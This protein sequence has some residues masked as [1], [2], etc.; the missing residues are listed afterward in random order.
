MHLKA[1]VVAGFALNFIPPAFADPNIIA[2]FAAFSQAGGSASNFPLNIDAVGITSEHYQQLYDPSLFF[3]GP[4][5]LY[6]LVLRPAAGRDGTK[7]ATTLPAIRFSL[8]T[9]AHSLADASTTFAGN[10]GADAQTVFDGALAI[11]SAARGFP[12]GNKAWDILIPFATPFAYDPTKGAL[13]LDV[14]NS[15]GGATTA[16]DFFSGNVPEVGVLVTTRLQDATSPA[17]LWLAS[18]GLASE[19]LTT[20]FVPN[21][22]S[23]PISA[24]LGLAGLAL[25]IGARSRTPSTR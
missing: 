21:P 2:P 18:S 1:L 17:G 5:S 14:V 10:I 22:V 4:V 3:R 15:G 16:L 7:F 12:N 19:F 11:T 20:P 6:G 23:E 25:A 13:L 24:V 9:A 8:S